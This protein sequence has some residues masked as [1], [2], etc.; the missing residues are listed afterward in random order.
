MAVKC[1]NETV[2]EE[3]EKIICM[4]GNGREQQQ[5]KLA[6]IQFIIHIENGT[7]WRLKKHQKVFALLMSLVKA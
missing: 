5:Q 6:H 1:A 7:K 3:E 2:K 4:C